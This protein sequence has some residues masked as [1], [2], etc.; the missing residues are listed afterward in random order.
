MVPERTAPPLAGSCSGPDRSYDA[1]W[2]RNRVEDILAQLYGHS[3]YHRG[4]VAQLV[5][6]LDEKPVTTDFIFWAREPIDEPK[7]R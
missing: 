2:F 1:G 3:L 7:P 6:S 5:R 4:Q